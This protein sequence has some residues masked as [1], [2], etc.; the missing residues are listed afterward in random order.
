[1]VVQPREDGTGAVRRPIDVE[2]RVVRDAE[3]HAVRVGRTN[4]RQA[5][6]D[7]R[8]RIARVR[9]A[10]GR[11]G[12]ERVHDVLVRIIEREVGEERLV[13]DRGLGDEAV[14]AARSRIRIVCDAPIAFPQKLLRAGRALDAEQQVAAIGCEAEEPRDRH[15]LIAAVLG[16][17]ETDADLGTLEVVLRMKLTTPPTASA[18]YTADAPPEITS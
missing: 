7:E 2:G 6:S 14:R 3:I 15:F 10:R 9:R 13:A 5:D 8:R 4:A 12:K 11:F 16:V 1:G 17:G 18:P